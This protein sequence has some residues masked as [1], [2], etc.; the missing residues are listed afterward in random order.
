M[1]L[2]ERAR[3]PRIGLAVCLALLASLTAGC[4]VKPLY[5]DMAS[6]T[7]SLAGSDQRLAS[8]AVKPE[9]SRIGLEVRNQLIFLLN[10]GAAQ[11]AN[12]AYTLE[13]GV[14]S[15]NDITAVVQQTKDTEPTAGSIIVTSAYR[16]T[17]AATGR[18]IASGRRSIASSYDIPR[19]EFAAIRAERD[20]QNRAAR[21]LAE[22]MRHTV[23]QELDRLPSS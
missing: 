17:E 10:G 2:S 16:L 14:F 23:A 11:P 3:T 21:E 4:T 7:G 18:I 1:S 15:Q 5:S 22:L 19:Q 6:T 9:T 8:V 12:P 13:L 20:A